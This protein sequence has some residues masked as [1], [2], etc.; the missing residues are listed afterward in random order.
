MRLREERQ[1][2]DRSV[3]SLTTFR[4]KFKPSGSSCQTPTSLQIPPQLFSNQMLPYHPLKYFLINI[5]F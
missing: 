3:D 1:G 4:G 2:A 5:S